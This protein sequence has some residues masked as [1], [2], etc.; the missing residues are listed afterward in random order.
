MKNISPQFFDN[1]QGS[2]KYIELC[3]NKMKGI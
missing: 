1:Y 2:Y 3:G